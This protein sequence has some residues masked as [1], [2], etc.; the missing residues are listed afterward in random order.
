VSVNLLASPDKILAYYISFIILCGI[1][2]TFVPFY[3]QAKKQFFKS[4]L[5][6]ITIG[7]VKLIFPVIFLFLGILTIRTTLL[8][9]GI[10]LIVAGIFGFVL[11]GI[12]FLKS[13]P[14]KETHLELVKYSGWIGLNRI[15]S[16]ISGKLD[17]Q[18]L[19]VISGAAVTGL[20]SIP[21]RLAS[22]VTVISSSFSSVLAPRFSSFADKESGKKYL[23][24]A[25]FVSLAISV[26]I[27]FWIIIAKPFV[28]I[29]FGQKYAE[30]VPVFK[31]L[32][33]AYIP[34]VLA[35]PSVTVIIYAMKKTIYIGLFSFFQLAAIFLINQIYIPKIGSFAPL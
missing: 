27:I 5:I 32:I 18:M 35:V 17:I 30:S 21:S 28:V 24:K 20:Y 2:W 1:A 25:L 13:K 31:G 10:S 3:L 11:T 34:Y 14:K 29:L 4:S 23:F 19:T 26:G 33:A 9:F 12:D 8:S 15:I 16:S 6:E 22:F 7:L